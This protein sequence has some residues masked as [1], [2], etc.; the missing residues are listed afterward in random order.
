M[1]F[2]EE[3]HLPLASTNSQSKAVLSAVELVVKAVETM[4]VIQASSV[5]VLLFFSAST[6]VM[7]SLCLFITRL[8]ALCLCRSRSC[9]FVPLPQC[10]DILSRSDREIFLLGDLTTALVVIVRGTYGGD[11]ARLSFGNLARGAASAN[12]VNTVTTTKFEWR[13]FEH[14][15]FWN[16]TTA[17]TRHKLAQ[18]TL[19]VYF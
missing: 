13:K 14:N 4:M 11:S 3:R 15:Y 19:I 17:R 12:A 9:F 16:T 2:F 6:A 5:R 1:M 8:D 18:P 10:T 7:G